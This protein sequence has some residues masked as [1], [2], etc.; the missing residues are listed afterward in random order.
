MK[1]VRGDPFLL[2]LIVR[3]LLTLNQGRDLDRE[4]PLSLVLFN[5]VTDVFTRILMKATRK[6]YI[7]C[8]MESLYPVGVISMQYS[9]DTLLFLKH[10]LESAYQLKWLM[11]CFEPIFGMK[12]NYHKS[13]M[14]P[15][16]LEEDETQTYGRIFCC[17]LR[18]FPFKY[19]GVSLYHEKLKREDIQPVIDTIM[20]RI[21][22]G[23]GD[24]PLMLPG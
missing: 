14:A 22:A 24:F 9:D 11:T 23:M 5:L 4:T 16:N 1:L 19:L 3:T 15:I 21:L 6:D 7:T 8:F 12:I 2:A 20:N 13:D 18:G 17:K 10:D